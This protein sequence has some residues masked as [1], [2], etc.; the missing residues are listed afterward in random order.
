MN[1]NIIKPRKIYLSLIILSFIMAGC[2]VDYKDFNTAGKITTDTTAIKMNLDLFVSGSWISNQAV[3]ASDE[4]MKVDKYD[5]FIFSVSSDGNYLEYKET[6]IVPDIF[7]KVASSNNIKVGHK[8]IVLQTGGSKRVVAVANGNNKIS[9]PTLRSISESEIPDLSD[10]TVYED[11]MA[12][13]C[14]NAIN[15]QTG[16]FVLFG[17]SLVSDANETNALVVMSN[18]YT[19]VN[20]KKSIEISLSSVQLLNVPVKAYPL[21]NNYDKLKPEFVDYSIIQVDNGMSENVVSDKL[22][23]LF[24]PGTNV[25]KDYRVA[26][27]V[28]GKING[29]DFQE[30]FYCPN[31]MYPGYFY[32]MNLF[33]SDGVVKATFTPNWQE[34]SF[35]I[36][37]VQLKN[38]QLIFPFTSDKYWGYEISWV[39]DISGEIVVKKDGN[40]PW[41]TVA[42][43]KNL[44]RVC[45][46][47]DNF[48]ADRSASFRVSLGKKEEI[49]TI[50]QQGIPQTTVTFN[51]IKWMDRNLG[52]TLP[53]TEENITNPDTYGYYYQWGR[54]IPF[55]TFGEIDVV[56]SDPSRTVMDAHNIK[57]FIAG[58]S[59]FT[60]DWWTNGPLISNR[61]TVW[62]DRTG[63]LGVPCPDGYHIP[64]YMEYQ[65][66]LPYKNSAGIGNFANVMSVLNTGEILDN[67]G[68][69]YECLY[70]TSD[71]LGATIYAIKKYKTEGA[72]YLR[73][74]RVETVG[75]KYLRID[76][77]AG[78]STSDF[79]GGDAAAKLNA[80][81][82]I[83]NA[84]TSMET[85]YFPAAGRRDRTTGKPVNQGLA[86]FAWSATCWD[87][88]TSSI[89]FDPV[90]SNTRIYNMA[91]SRAHAQSVRCIK[92]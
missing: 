45:C 35:S 14:V 15:L 55:P 10:V 88:N 27:L 92:D 38:N 6:D 44:I 91:N 37:G 69:Q 17:N 49:I 20:I 90:G 72:Y 67:T 34:G 51:G 32:T 19:K 21:I 79:A 41:Y 73:W 18:Q 16:P 36:T 59:G 39:T 48:S 31:P 52:A 87:A 78:N 47:Q 2:E 33:S 25:E 50:T 30:T 5:L 26:V 43:D 80:A 54:N 89:Y 11:F 81:A 40:E 85:I 74:R 1:T 57:E 46:I 86:L 29:V 8:E 63:T 24:T 13:C 77:I 58:S 22:Y 64:S 42:I 9:Y 56:D 53:S 23:V 4:E 75:G 61:T 65:T 28:K 84:A 71:A 83:F 60:Y 66:I 70:V 3:N 12:A 7:E 82:A 62:T 76:R 68:V